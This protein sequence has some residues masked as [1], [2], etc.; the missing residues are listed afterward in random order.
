[1]EEAKQLLA[2]NYKDVAAEIKNQMLTAA[3][4]L[5]F[6]LAAT[7]RDKLNAVEAWASGS[8]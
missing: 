3:D 4:N 2:G 5:E 1:M 8:W 7:L 6:E